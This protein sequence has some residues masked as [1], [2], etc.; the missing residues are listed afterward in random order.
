[1]PR[2]VRFRFFPSLR[3][4][5]YGELPM[6]ISDYFI[7]GDVKG[8]I[9]YMRSHEGFAD[10]LPLY[11]ALFEDAQYRRYEVPAPLGRVLLAYQ[12][13]F[14][15]VFYCRTPQVE[16]E[17]KLFSSL[18]A[19][20]NL[21]AAEEAELSEALRALFETYGYHS[22]YGRTQGYYGPYIWRET[23]E[24]VYQ[25]ELPCSVQAYSVHILRGFVFRSWMDYLTFGRF[26][27]AGW[28]SPGG[29]INCIDQAYD[30][31]SEKFLVSLL[32]HEAQHIADMAQYPGISPAELEYRAKLVELHYAQQP[33]LLQK[34]SAAAQ[35]A[36]PADS[37]AAASARICEAFAPL[38]GADLV[39]IRAKALELFLAD[40]QVMAE[41]YCS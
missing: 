35:A 20:V 8:A 6:Q 23:E 16:A 39:E 34:F 1:L 7:A 26:G 25:V 5:Y 41:K 21:P 14:R 37:H 4:L 11:T 10:V 3:M 24:A 2:S 32:K 13:Y 17:H 36:G 29:I 30:F 38:A 22:Q 31:N 9:A 33:G 12:V 19:A 27:T 15:D 18:R 28:A 40:N